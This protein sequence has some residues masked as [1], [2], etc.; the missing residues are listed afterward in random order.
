MKKLFLLVVVFFSGVAL[1]QPIDGVTIIIQSARIP[2][3]EVPDFATTLEREIDGLYLEGNY[4]QALEKARYFMILGLLHNNELLQAHYELFSA[5]ALSRQGKFQE[6]FIHLAQAYPIYTKLHH[7]QYQFLALETLVRVATNLNYWEEA[8]N[9]LTELE[10]L[11]QHLKGMY[12]EMYL[13]H[14][15]VMHFH[16]NRFGEARKD[17]EEAEKEAV[18]YPETRGLTLNHMSRVFLQEENPEKVLEY[19]QRALSFS[20]GRNLRWVELVVR[21]NLAQILSE[22]LGE[23]DTSGR[24]MK[25]SNTFGLL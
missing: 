10:K 15:G 20:T 8:Q 16:E 6:A 7:E 5:R 22:Y 2:P 3:E 1:A 24:K 9:Y 4:S 25:P 23:E 18:F 12:Q 17:W 13:F 21:L 14:L 11:A 19:A